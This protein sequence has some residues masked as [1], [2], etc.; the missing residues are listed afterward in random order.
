MGN[1]SAIGACR[2]V[3]MRSLDREEVSVWVGVKKRVLRLSG[4]GRGL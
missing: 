1:N 4:K 3:E 2:C